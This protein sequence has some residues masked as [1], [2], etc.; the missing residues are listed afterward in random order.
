M[1]DAPSSTTAEAGFTLTEILVVILIIGVLAAIAVPTLLG[2]RD[3]GRDAEAKTAIAAVVR[4]MVI[5]SQNNNNSTACGDAAGCLAEVRD[6]EHAIPSAGVTISAPGGTIGNAHGDG[7]RVTVVGGD[8]RTFW[9]ERTD[10]GRDRGCDL[11]GARSQ[12]GCNGGSW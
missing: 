10:T 4:A 6:I 12:G 5:Y 3:R 1:R 8:G 7:Y 9:E 11:N 2:E